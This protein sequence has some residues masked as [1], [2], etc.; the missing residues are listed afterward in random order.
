M[1]LKRLEQ[2]RSLVQEIKELG[3]QLSNQQIESDTVKGSLTEYPYIETTVTIRGLNTKII[4]RLRRRQTK[5]MME[6][7]AI[8]RYIDSIDDSLTRRVINLRYVQGYGW[9]KLARNIG[10]NTAD[11][12]R[13]LVVRHVR[14][15]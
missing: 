15:F 10:G 12:L 1:T 8:E 7:L 4:E 9:H 6:R 2:Y 5:L 11:S 13:M 3:Q 14:G